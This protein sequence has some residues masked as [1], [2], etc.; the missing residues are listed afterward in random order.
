MANQLPQPS[1]INPNYIVDIGIECHVQL[2]TNSKLFCGCSNDAREAEPNTLICP[3]C[4][5]MPGTLPVLNKAAV[6]LAIRA[7][8]ALNA[9]IASD[10][11][12][13]RKNY[14]YP[15]LP[16]GYQITQ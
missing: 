4:L 16:K 5:G 3:I 1:V 15:D 14:F 6:E 2:K 13:D 8:L 12:F 7:G 11:K 9:E 10:T